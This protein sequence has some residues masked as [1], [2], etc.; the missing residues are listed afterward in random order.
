MK[1]ESAKAG[2]YL[3]MKTKVLTIEEK[4]NLNTGNKDTEAVKDFAYFSSVINYF[5]LNG[6]FSKEMK[7]GLSL[8]R[9]AMKE[10]GKITKNM[11]VIS[12]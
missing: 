1:K 12:N 4:H 9:E 3:N 2:F 7:R 5:S 10:L 8:E 6:N 11:C